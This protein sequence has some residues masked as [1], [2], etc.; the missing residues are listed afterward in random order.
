MPTR[1]AARFGH[2]R[3]RPQ[4]VQTRRRC[5]RNRRD[6]SGGPV[7]GTTRLFAPTR[8]VRG[9]YGWCTKNYSP[10]T[11]ECLHASLRTTRQRRQLFVKQRLHRDWDGRATRSSQ[12]LTRPPRAPRG[13]GAARPASHGRHA[14]TAGQTHAP[15]FRP[16]PLNRDATASWARRV[17]CLCL[18]AF[19]HLFSGVCLFLLASASFCSLKTAAAQP[20]RLP[21]NG[22][23]VVSRTRALRACRF[24][25][26]PA[27]TRTTRDRT[28][29]PPFSGRR[30]PS[31]GP[32][33]PFVAGN[34]RRR[35]R[36]RRE[37]SW[38]SSAG[39]TQVIAASR[40]EQHR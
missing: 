17:P 24:P 18:N 40:Q 19:C 23:S 27:G 14:V 36:R 4:K 15:D 32:A 1:E 34:G 2:P 11:D 16:S 22:T 10:R 3:F 6:A 13:A 8:R 29:A 31:P 39:R 26:A 5:R 12:E 9:V 35:R 37:F 28:Y 7:F 30:P 33:A 21:R 20:P 25:S 38:F